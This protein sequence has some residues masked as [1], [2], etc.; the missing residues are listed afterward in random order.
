MDIDN[1]KVGDRSLAGLKAL[2]KK[3]KKLYKSTG[4]EDTDKIKLLS[5]IGDLEE[6]IRYGQFKEQLLNGEA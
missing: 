5:V 1:G 3:A 4:T 6:K 2:K